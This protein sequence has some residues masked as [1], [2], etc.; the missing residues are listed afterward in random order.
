MSNWSPI[1]IVWRKNPMHC[2]KLCK[3]QHHGLFAW[4]RPQ[5]QDELSRFARCFSIWLTFVM[6]LWSRFS[7][8]VWKIYRYFN[9]LRSLFLCLCYWRCAEMS[10]RRIARVELALRQIVPS[11]SWW[12]QVFPF[13]LPGGTNMQCLL[14]HSSWD[15]ALP[16]NGILISSSVFAGA[17]GSDVTNGSSCTRAQQVRGAKLHHRNILW[18]T[19][20]KRE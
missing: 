10:R 2:A 9:L 6:H 16:P 19:N 5:F 15:H 18:L 12:R 3:L 7:S 4:T 8:V 1:S 17:H 11:P 14:T 20:T 13:R